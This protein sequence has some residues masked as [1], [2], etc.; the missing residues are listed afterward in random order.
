MLGALASAENWR[1][2]DDAAISLGQDALRYSYLAGDVIGIGVCHHN[3]GNYLRRRPA[4]AFTH[5]LAAALIYR[6]AGAGRADQSTRAAAFDLRMFGERV[7]MPANVADLCSQV[8][9][10]PGVDLGRLITALVPDSDTAE[11]VFQE[12]LTRVRTLAVEPSTGTSWY[13]AAWDPLISALLAADVGDA[14]AAAALDTQ[15][16]RYQDSPDWGALAAVLRR[17]RAGDTESDLLNGLDE[18]DTAIVTRAIDARS[19]KVSIP[20]D[21]WQAMG[22]GSLLSELVAGATGNAEAAGRAR[23]ALEQMIGKPELA[24]LAAVLGRILDGERDPGLAGQLGDPAYQA[25]VTTVLYH[26]GVR[27]EP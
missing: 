27:S 26:I 18:I 20:S 6:L 17:L 25:V 24:P 23:Q 9:T 19:G 2:H 22:I 5:R 11:R 13:L 10:V 21:L 4:D 3:L 16:D 12:L 7:T 8:A 15:L 1:G 14:G